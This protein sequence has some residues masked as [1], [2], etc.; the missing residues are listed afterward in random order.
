MDTATLKRRATNQSIKGDTSLAKALQARL[1]ELG[2]LTG[3]AD[4]KWGPISIEC[5]ADFQACHA[6][7]DLSVNG[8]DLATAEA[9]TADKPPIPF[10]LG[11]GLASQI[12]GRML[13]LGM[14]VASGNSIFNIVYLEGANSDGSLNS[15][16]LNV[17]N[18][19]RIVFQ[20]IP[21]KKPKIVG[22]WDAS[23]EPG[24]HYTYHRMNEKGAARIALD[25]QFKSWMLGLHGYSN[26]HSALVQVAPIEVY[27]DD[28]EDG[29]RVGD[30]VDIGCFAINQ[31]SGYNNP[32]N[33][34]GRA[35]AGCLVGR[36]Q[37]GH[38]QFMRLIKRDVR[39]QANPRYL[40]YTAVLDPAKL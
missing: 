27:R 16:R 24:A 25:A 11:T 30:A 19:Q 6:P 31:H 3:K 5:L 34:V 9:L 28:N 14:K 17:F 21:G 29:S 8:Y 38:D 20:I 23:C 32:T 2:F 36:T 26:P 33:N 37:S 40:F 1:I 7:G 39:C 13:D 35:S 18:D 4:G 22:K 10:E 12:A 15:D